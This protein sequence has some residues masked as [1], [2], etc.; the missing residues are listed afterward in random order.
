MNRTTDPTNDLAADRSGAAGHPSPR[1]HRLAGLL[2]AL[3]LGAG[4]MSVA[5]VADAAH[6]APQTSKAA[7]KASCIRRGGSWS[8][9]T[10][11]GRCTLR[12]RAGGVD[13][14]INYDQL[15]RNIGS[16]IY[17]WPGD[18]YCAG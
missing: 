9:T 2:L 14:V 8:N 12:G 18:K 7:A 17:Y 4:V 6:P 13:V 1:R 11:G 15:G 16:C 3:G 10:F 5:G